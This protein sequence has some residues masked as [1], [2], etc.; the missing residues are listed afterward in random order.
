MPGQAAHEWAN[1]L[2]SSAASLSR[3]RPNEKLLRRGSEMYFHFL[4][5]YELGAPGQKGL[6]PGSELG[7][8]IAM[9][10]L[11]LISLRSRS[12]SRSLKS[13][14]SLRLSHLSLKIAAS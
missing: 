8:P 1:M 2:T 6:E 11:F 7:K 5:V 10:V 3:M 9:S 4:P 12:P 14:N 13:D